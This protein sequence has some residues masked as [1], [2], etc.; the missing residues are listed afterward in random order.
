MPPRPVPAA[1]NAVKRNKEKEKQLRRNNPQFDD[2]AEFIQ[3]TG[4]TIYTEQERRNQEVAKN[5]KYAEKLADRRAQAADRVWREQHG[6]PHQNEVKGFYD[7]KAIQIFVA[8]LIILNFFVSA[9]EAQMFPLEPIPGKDDAAILAFTISEYFFA[10]VFLIELLVNFYGNYFWEFWK[11]A[12]NIFDFLIVLISLLAL[13][14]QDLPG[15]SVLRLFRAFRVVRLFKRIKTMRTMMDGVLRSLPGMSIAFIALF[16]IMGI[17]GII[18]VNFWA[19]SHETYFGN[20]LKAVLSLL[21]IMTFDSW[22]SG[23][24]RPVILSPQG[25]AVA[26]IY[27][28]S[29]VFIASIIMANVLIALLLDEFMSTSSEAD[30]ED[31]YSDE[32]EDE[33]LDK[34]VEDNHARLEEKFM[35]EGR[36]SGLV[37]ISAGLQSLM[38]QGDQNGTQRDATPPSVSGGVGGGGGGGIEMTSYRKNHGQTRA[39]S[40][41]PSYGDGSGSLNA[42]MRKGSAND[43]KWRQKVD[44]NIRTLTR[45]LDKL[46]QKLDQLLP[47]ASPGGGGGPNPGPDYLR[48]T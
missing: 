11:S 19:E 13:Y 4:R 8:G 2:A 29:Y 12:W 44:Q 43:P 17:Y 41:N 48:A 42:D 38:Q 27:F 14:M 28:I 45:S 47:H 10:Y 20:F 31:D 34:I 46:H 35:G 6:L 21:Q 16:L 24:A 1:L 36:H 15:I 26:A 7:R 39:T 18:G 32:D 25:G 3:S 30:A 22:S 9:I 23:I 5:R 37:A 40:S 33:A